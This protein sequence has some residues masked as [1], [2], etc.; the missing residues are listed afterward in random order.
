[1]PAYH[2]L[3]DGD[4]AQVRGP[5]QHRDDLAVPDVRQRIGP[6][7]TKTVAGLLPGRQARVSLYPVASAGAEP[8][9][10][11]RGGP[12]MPRS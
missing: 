10:R 3:K 2:L 4:R 9:H 7:A 5:L 12:G 8:C 6:T 11:R 1:M